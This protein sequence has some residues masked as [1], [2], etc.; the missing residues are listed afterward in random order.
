MLQIG[1]SFLTPHSPAQMGPFLGSF[2]F[3]ITKKIRVVFP[4]PHCRT[5]AALLP[6]RDVV[7]GGI[8][9][10][11]LTP[12]FTHG[13]R[14]ALTSMLRDQSRHVCIDS[15]VPVVKCPP[16]NGE[17]LGE[18]TLRE[19]AFILAVCILSFR[20]NPIAQEAHLA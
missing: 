14:A 20:K 9:V 8:G 12:G 15:R 7:S 4:R 1:R 10:Q 3:E 18:C 5:H 19:L 2:L 6:F 17:N 11:S 13:A 16:E